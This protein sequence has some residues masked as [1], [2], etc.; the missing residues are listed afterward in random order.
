MKISLDNIRR[1]AQY[2]GDKQSGEMIET[3]GYKKSHLDLKSPV[4]QVELNAICEMFNTYVLSEGE[5]RLYNHMGEIIYSI[6][7]SP[8]SNL[9]DIIRDKIEREDTKQSDIVLKIHNVIIETLGCTKDDITPSARLTEDLD[10]DSL[11][12]VELCMGLEEVF[13]IE[14]PDEEAEQMRTVQDIITY[15]ESRE[16]DILI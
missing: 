14:I 15:M 5:G 2:I 13:E 4:S 1:V 3:T 12:S 10:A 8:P 7:E 16:S 11:D 6:P 9:G